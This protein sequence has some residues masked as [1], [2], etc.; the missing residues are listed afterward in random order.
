MSDELR[1]VGWYEFKQRD[2]RKYIDMTIAGDEEIQRLREKMLEE[3]KLG[4]KSDPMMKSMI[5]WVDNLSDVVNLHLVWIN[6]LREG[7]IEIEDR[8]DKLEK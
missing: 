2:L 8:L 6:A 3:E 1:P 7:L 4:K 5:T